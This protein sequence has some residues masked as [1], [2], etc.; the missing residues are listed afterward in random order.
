MNVAR[1]AFGRTIA[2]TNIPLAE[3]RE[4]LVSKPN[5]VVIVLDDVGF[6]QLGCFGSDVATPSFDRLA[7]AGLRYNRFHVTSLCSPTRA[8]LLTGRNHHAVGMG[9]VP[10]LPL[11]LPGYS[12]RIPRS[13][14]TLAR[15]LRDAGYSTMALGKW[16]LTPR[17]DRTA[18]GPFDLWPLGQGFE[19]FYGFL[20]ADTNQWTPNLVCDNHFVEPP[21][22]PEQGYH[23][24]A[25]LVDVAIRQLR[26]QQN[27][28]PEKPFFLYLATGAQH[29]PHQVPPE[30]IEAYRGHFDGGWER[31][32]RETFER[33]KVCGVVPED[34]ACSQR[35]SWVQDWDG[36]P[37]GEQRLYARMQEV[38][39]GFLTHTDHH[40]GRLFDC[41]EELNVD[42]N[43]VVIALSDNGAS[44]EGSSIGSVNEGRFTLDL[45][46][47]ADN[48]AHIDDLGGFRLYNHYPWG[49]A[50]AGNTPFRL[51][52]RYAWLGGTRVPLIIRWPAGIENCGEVRQ[53][54]SHVVDIAPSIL[55]LC[56]VSP[57]EV[58]DGISQQ[59]LD[60]ASLRTTFGSSSAPSPR[61]VQYFEMLGSRS[62]YAGRWKATTDRVVHGVADEERLVTGSHSLEADTW[63]LFDLEEDFAEVNDLAIQHPDVV[64]RLADMWWSEAGRNSVLPM[65]N[66]LDRRSPTDLMSA[67]QPPPPSMFSRKTF[68]PGG[69]PIADEAVP[70]LS[71]GGE[72][73]IDV[74]VPGTVPDGVLCAQ[75][76]WT[77]G[78]A[79]IILASRPTYVLN[80]VGREYR[81]EA[82]NPLNPGRHIVGFSYA[83]QSGSRAAISVTIDGEVVGSGEFA[84]GTPIGT[85]QA[86]GS[87]LR[88]G[89]DVGF[90]VSGDYTPPFA[91]AGTIHA[92]TVT[93]RPS[94]PV[95][96][97]ELALDAI[98]RD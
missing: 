56:D 11:R 88:I 36:L 30:W 98:H 82:A 72:V 83:P 67:M 85:G 2:E 42:Q 50:W 1:S 54:L 4:P 80:S 16:H 22:P 7:S 71:F 46:D 9:F 79:L 31:W 25:D 45:D 33:Q 55:D 23:L 86:D 70:M 92:V 20:H 14:A 13:A 60:G 10:D 32:R 38:F 6:A 21:R 87:G 44:A 93:P 68:R 3:S 76:N 41:L 47:L 77:G 51:W 96:T 8:S 40:V 73:E 91:W 84:A 24:T 15:H 90:P 48:L 28:T 29:A 39:A 17:Y 65:G 26:A 94:R 19:R 74:D 78:W 95:D 27:A 63:A 35:P 64:Q 5:V 57:D 43:T 97:S 59:P 89:H 62:I 49:W 69:G 66:W 61:D 34:A 18:S 58:I 81:I 52:K 12:G 53:Q 37:Q 75:G